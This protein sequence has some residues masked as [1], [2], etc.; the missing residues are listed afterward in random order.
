MY[1]G[2]KV[3]G[4]RGVVSAELPN[5]ARLNVLVGPNGCGKTTLLE[6]LALGACHNQEISATAFWRFL[7]DHREGGGW[8][9]PAMLV[10]GPQAEVELLSSETTPRSVLIK[11]DANLNPRL[12]LDGSG[13]HSVALPGPQEG[14]GNA[15]GYVQMLGFRFIGVDRGLLDNFE[16]AWSSAERAGARRQVVELLKPVLPSVSDLRLLREAWG[17]N[18]T[19]N[20]EEASGSGPDRIWPLHLAGDGIKRLV[21]LASRLAGT[22]GTLVL[23]EDPDA[24]QHRRSLKQVSKVLW[25]AAKAGAQLVITTHSLELL[26]LLVADVNGPPEADQL[27]IFALEKQ[28][29]GALNVIRKS[30]AQFQGDHRRQTIKDLMG[31]ST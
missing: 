20:V 15:S 14:K 4:L 18:T 6:A 22:S 17:P 23:I 12:Y 7:M 30:A 2:L 8:R 29:S 16:E 13:G 25:A 9:F 28:P 31:Y 26:D 24:F 5:L 1:T 21:L 27:A 19:L 10:P 3:N 11:M